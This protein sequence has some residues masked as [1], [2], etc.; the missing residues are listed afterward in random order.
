MLFRVAI[1]V[2]KLSIKVTGKVKV[3]S[4]DFYKTLLHAARISSK[5]KM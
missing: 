5:L 1:W 2:K 4:I 3:Q